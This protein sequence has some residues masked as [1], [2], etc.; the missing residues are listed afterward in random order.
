MQK[1][2]IEREIP[3]IGEAPADALAGA[4]AKSNGVLS[5]MTKEAK[6]IQWEHSYVTG[7]RTFCIYF[8]ESEDLIHEHAEQ[9]GFPASK[10]SRVSTMIDPMTANQ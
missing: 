9:S 6:G 3:N 7:D 8:A 1:Y 5:S 10:I 2:V 4:A